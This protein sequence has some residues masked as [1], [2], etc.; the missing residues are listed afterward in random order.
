VPDEQ[1]KVSMRSPLM[2]PKMALIDPLLTHDM[3]P[4]LTAA[5]GLDALTQL[6]EAFVSCKANP[7]TDGL[8]REGLQRAGRSLRRAF[9]DGQD[10]EARCD[11][12]LASLFSGLAL[13]NAGLG[14]VHGIAAPLGGMTAAP[15]GAVCARLLPF[16]TAAN[17]EALETGPEAGSYLRR[18]QEA[19]T[20]L[21]GNPGAAARDLVRW[22]DELSADLQI[23]S[24]SRWGLQPGQVPEL[25]AQS[26][27]SSS[28]RGNP[29]PLDSKTLEGI[30]AQ[31]MAKD[32]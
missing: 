23:A 19:A 9:D 6:V 13:A 21:T 17:I 5:T 30:I 24:L 2:L 20:L 28:M 1:V 12:A 14:A 32:G 22:L 4:N 3:P 10:A 16:V 29:V 7:L 25:A 27:K 31:A 11:M 8:C 18:Y 26:L 15:H